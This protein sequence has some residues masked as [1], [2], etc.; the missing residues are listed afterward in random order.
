M[1]LECYR[2]AKFDVKGRYE[3]LILVAGGIGISPFLAI[4]SDIL[5]RFRESK[6]CLP[7]NIQIVWA[8]KKS[9]ELLLLHSLNINLIFPYF[10]NLLN[11][12]IQ[13]YVTRE[14]EPPLEEGKIPNYVNSSKFSAPIGGGMSSLVG[15]GHIIWSGAYMVVST[16]GLVVLIAY[17]NI[18]YINPYNITHW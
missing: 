10:Y 1:Y 9:D 17:L 12:E 5:H 4:L 15:M 18:F 11:L 14:S 7:R 8:I 13:T 16:I 2:A 3:N 6:P